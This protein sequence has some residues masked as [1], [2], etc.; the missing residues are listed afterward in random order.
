MTLPSTTDT[1]HRPLTGVRI[2]SLSLNLPGPA[3]LQ[4]LRQ[5]GATCVKLEPPAPL[6]SSASGVQSGVTGDPM[7]LYSPAAYL[8]L[9]EGIQVQ[10]VNLKTDVGQATLHTELAQANVLL[11]SFRPGALS[12]LRLDWASL[13]PRYPCLSMVAIVGAPGAG[14]D[15]PGHDLTYVAENDLITGLDLP[16]TLYADMGGALMASEAVLR[17][18][19]LQRPSGQGC[20]LEVALSDAAAHLALPRTWGAT[21]PGT[22]LGGGHAGYRVY[23]CLDGRVALAALEPHFAQ[24]LCAVAG[25][26][27]RG[28]DMMLEMPTHQAISSFVATLSREALETLARE[29]DIPLHALL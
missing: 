28:L 3:A 19:L 18:L 9:H 5:M 15:L 13:Q 24:S 20:F 27:W 4:R 8:A 10:A 22:L 26:P 17:A 25:L 6:A 12:K 11:T 14:A 1:R 23:P 7:S 29:H 2:L 21:L 16:A